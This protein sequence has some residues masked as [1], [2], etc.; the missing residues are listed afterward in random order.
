MT[1]PTKPT[2]ILVSFLI[3]SGF[4]LTMAFLQRKARPVK[5]GDIIPM[6]DGQTIDFC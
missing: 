6:V 1:S 4:C 5:L 3:F 2:A